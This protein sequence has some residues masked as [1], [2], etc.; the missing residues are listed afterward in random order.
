MRTGPARA[1]GHRRRRDDS[2]DAE[3]PRAG[4][5]G[6]G[7]SV[8]GRRHAGEPGRGRDPR[9]G[10]G[11]PGVGRERPRVHRLPARVGADAGGPRASGGGRR[12]PRAARARLDVLR[13]QRA[14][15]PPRRGDLQGDAVRGED[16]VLQLRHRG[17]ALRDARRAGVPP[18]GPH[19]EVRGRLPRHARLRRDGHEPAGAGPVPGGGA[20]LGGHPPGRRVDDARRAV[21]RPRDD[22]RHRRPAPR[23]AGGGHR[24]AVP[25][26]AG[27]APRFP[28]GAARAD[29]PARH[30][31]HL[32][33]GR[34]LV[35][36][37]LRR[38]AGVLRRD[39]GPL[40]ARQGGGRRL[41]ADGRR[42]ARGAHGALR[43]EPRGPGAVHPAGRH[44]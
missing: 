3:R 36:V 18:P 9:A 33:R 10:A 29:R 14:R 42:G 13:E 27:A 35:P 16:P 43:P 28:G 8:P 19:P 25:A 20:G 22:E 26:R 31:A 41:P 21:Q 6:E 7:G 5:G 15:H 30:P 32:R 44:A 37:R 2:A 24:R 12:R 11:Q 1:A 34:D 4:A 17:D 38:R 39:A 40:R 23:R